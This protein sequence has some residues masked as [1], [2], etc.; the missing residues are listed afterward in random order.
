MIRGLICLGV[1]H[2]YPDH[3]GISQQCRRCGQWW[4]HYGPR[5]QL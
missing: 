3:D 2:D 1:G 5:R 4:Q